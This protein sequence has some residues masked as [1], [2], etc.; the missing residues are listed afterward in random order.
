[1]A[2]AILYTQLLWL[3][4]FPAPIIASVPSFFSLMGTSWEVISAI[5]ASNAIQIGALL[6]N[7]E[8]PKHVP[9][10]SKSRLLPP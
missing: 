6:A 7:Q 4:A 9:R 2:R 1:V 10:E 8:T 3:S 5:F